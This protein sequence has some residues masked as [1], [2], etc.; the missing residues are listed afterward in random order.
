MTEL[1]IEAPSAARAQMMVLRGRWALAAFA[2]LDVDRVRG[3]VEAVGEVAYQ[4]AKRF[5][6]DTV[7]ETGM[8]IVEHKR[9]QLG[10]ILLVPLGSENDELTA[11][12][13]VPNQLPGPQEPV[14]ILVPPQGR[15]EQHERS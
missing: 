7:L 15:D 6:K 1:A 14:A 8:G 13:L 10:A 4:N 9:V 11:C 2:S 5:A 3:I 12:E